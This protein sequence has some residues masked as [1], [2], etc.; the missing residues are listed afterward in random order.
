MRIRRLLDEPSRQSRKLE[1]VQFNPKSLVR[2]RMRVAIPSGVEPAKMVAV[3][4]GVEPMGMVGCRWRFHSFFL[5]DL[6]VGNFK[7]IGVQ[8]VIHDS[9]ETAIVD[10]SPGRGGS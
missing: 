9:V 10:G 5:R 7:K 8:V 2:I 4:Y 6:R 1:G 3:L